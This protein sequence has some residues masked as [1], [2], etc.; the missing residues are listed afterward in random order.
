MKLILAIGS[1]HRGFAIKE[2][3]IKNNT[4]EH[5]EIEWRDVGCFSAERCDYPPFAAQV[6]HLVLEQEA[7]FGVLLCGSG[8]GMTIAANRFK[9]IYAGLVWNIESARLARSDD[10]INIISLPTD[11]ID[12]AQAVAIIGVSITTEFKGG[13]YA[14]RLNM[15]DVY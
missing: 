7:H 5:I 9:K 10:N 3:L 11:F 12:Y 1:D 13:R 6:A 15:I 8:I 14:E 2:L 4:I